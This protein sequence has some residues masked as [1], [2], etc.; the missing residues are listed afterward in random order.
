MKWPMA[1][2][3]PSNTPHIT[4]TIG[5]MYVTELAKRGVL[6]LTS[7]ANS[8]VA[9][10]VLM[11]PNNTINPKAFQAPGT[12]SILMVKSVKPNKKVIAMGPMNN[13]DTLVS[14]SEPR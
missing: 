11:Q 14:V 6:S 10:A 8:A 9:M 12:V 5:M 2:L 4:E 1:K 3:S 7:L 13:S